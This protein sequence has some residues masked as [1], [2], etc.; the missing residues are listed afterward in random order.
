MKD[1]SLIELLKGFGRK[2][3]NEDPYPEAAEHPVLHDLDILVLDPGHADCHLRGA[4]VD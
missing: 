4:Q 3:A 1:F 2:I